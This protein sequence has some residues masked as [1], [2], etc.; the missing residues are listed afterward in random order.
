V[1]VQLP[2]PSGI[3]QEKIVNLIG[4]DKDIDG[5]HPFN[6]GSLALKRHSP[7]FVSCT[8]LGVLRILEEILGSQEAIACQKVLIIGRSN[9]VGMPMFLLLNTLNAFCRIAFSFTPP[10]LLEQYVREADIVIA[11]CGVP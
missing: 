1:L 5:M 4:P 9:I 7:Y 6:I 3:D 11:A 2:L 10:E 8:P